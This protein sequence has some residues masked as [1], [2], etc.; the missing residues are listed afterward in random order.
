MH[1]EIHIDGFVEPPGAAELIARVRVGEGTIVHY[2]CLGCNEL[3]EAQDG[4][5][6]VHE[7]DTIAHQHVGRR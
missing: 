4:E 6:V 3:F 1:I 7:C 2:I 5:F